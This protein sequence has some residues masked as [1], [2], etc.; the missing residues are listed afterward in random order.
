MRYCCVTCFKACQ[1]NDASILAVCCKDTC[2]THATAY[3]SG[4]GHLGGHGTRRLKDVPRLH[5]LATAKYHRRSSELYLSSRAD[6]AC[7]QVEPQVLRDPCVVC[8]VCCAVMRHAPAPCRRCTKSRPARLT[9]T[10]RI[11]P[12]LTGCSA[13]PGLVESRT[14]RPEPM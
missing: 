5:Q 2:A 1:Q 13:A 4:Q 10:Q 7:G 3:G 9:A 14:C 6:V 11:P 8:K 12:P